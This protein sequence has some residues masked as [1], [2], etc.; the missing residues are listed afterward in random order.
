M[1][2]LPQPYSQHF[3]FYFCNICTFRCFSKLSVTSLC[4]TTVFTVCRYIMCCREA[5]FLMV[6]KASIQIGMLF[7][8]SLFLTL[9]IMISKV[10]KILCD[11][12]LEEGADHEWWE[13]RGR[14]VAHFSS[15]HCHLVRVFTLNSFF[16]S[17]QYLVKQL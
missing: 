5:L 14:R 16:F 15:R 9:H 8:L 2:S 6:I 7:P 4:D 13:V 1:A 12:G 10:R 17:F 3:F 11:A